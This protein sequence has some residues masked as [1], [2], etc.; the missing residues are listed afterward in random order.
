MCCALALAHWQVKNNQ[1]SL[2]QFE[3]EGDWRLLFPYLSGANLAQP[4]D[5]GQGLI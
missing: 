4:V 1:V 3:V 5:H 2:A